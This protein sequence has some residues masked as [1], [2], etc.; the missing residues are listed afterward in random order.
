[1]IKSISTCQECEKVVTKEMTKQNG[2]YRRYC[3]IACR[4]KAYYWKH[5]SKNHHDLR[6]LVRQCKYCGAD[7]NPK[8]WQQLYCSEKCQNQIKRRRWLMVEIN[9]EKN[10]KY[11]REYSWR[12]A[13]E[14]WKEKIC[15]TCGKSF[16]PDIHTKGGQIYCSVKCRTWFCSRTS[17]QNQRARQWKVEGKIT[18]KEWKEVLRKYDYKCALCGSDKKI[19]MDHIT[20]LSNG[21]KHEK[22]NIRVLCHACH[23]KEPNKGWFKKGYDDRRISSPS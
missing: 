16:L 8:V 3:S 9:R 18:T 21:G 6:G 13:R 5:W 17:R 19:E 14:N 12:K 23:K 20:S 10:R 2:G 22:N 11:A 7:F 1:M 4:S 15:E